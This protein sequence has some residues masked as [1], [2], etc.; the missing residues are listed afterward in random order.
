MV[1]LS[2]CAPGGQLFT[3]EIGHGEGDFFGGRNPANE[4]GGFG[5][6]AAA[7]ELG[8]GPVFVRQKEV[9]AMGVARND[10]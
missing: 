1:P 2:S 7:H 8:V 10:R 4:R 6:R 5:F 3:F 9:V